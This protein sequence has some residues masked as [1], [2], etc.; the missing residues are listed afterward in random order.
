MTAIEWLLQS[1]PPQQQSYLTCSSNPRVLPNTKQKQCHQK[2]QREGMPQVRRLVLSSGNLG[3]NLKL[4]LSTSRLSSKRNNASSNI[5][6]SQCM[7][8]ES[9]ET[10]YT[11]WPKLQKV[12]TT[13]GKETECFTYN[14]LV[15]TVGISYFLVATRQ[16]Q[17]TQTNHTQHC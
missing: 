15:S 10:N 13:L 12:K 5:M 9:W 2:Q 17:T 8:K 16:C 4:K 3:H 1:N 7:P 6:I 14:L 11:I